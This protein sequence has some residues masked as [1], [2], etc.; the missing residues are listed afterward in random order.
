MVIM[1]YVWYPDKKRK[2]GQRHVQRKDHMK[3]QGADG[4]LQAKEK[5]L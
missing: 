4:H 1:K 2:L 5:G 3:T